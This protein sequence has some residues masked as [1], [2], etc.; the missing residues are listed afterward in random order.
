MRVNTY[1]Y[2]CI[3]YKVLL[4]YELL[5]GDWSLHLEIS[6]LFSLLNQKLI[7]LNIYLFQCTQENLFTLCP[8]SL[9]FCLCKTTKEMPSIFTLRK[10]IENGYGLVR[11]FMIH[12]HTSRNLFSIRLSVCLTNSQ[13]Q[14]CEHIYLYGKKS[15]MYT[16]V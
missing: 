2:E 8:S 5:W 7:Y 15:C 9:T 4:L 12:S 1:K 11:L 13:G 10:K 14:G 6:T 3:Y 16:F